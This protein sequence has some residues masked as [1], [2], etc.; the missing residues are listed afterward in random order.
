LYDKEIVF[1]RTV[2]K[3]LC[4]AL[5]TAVVGQACLI[6][7]AAEDNKPKYKIKEVM[8]EAHKGGLLKKVTSGK[9]DKEDKEKLLEFY[10]ALSKNKPPKGDLDDW[11]ERT[12]TMV[13][14]AKEVVE[15]K[16]GAEKKLAKTVN[17]GACHSLHKP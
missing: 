3:C 14:V 16:E 1:M 17:C 12:G 7:S 9:A 8:K 6:L 5:G 10:I 2:V 15:A 4:V 11:K 13:V